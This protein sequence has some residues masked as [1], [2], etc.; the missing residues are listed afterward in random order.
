MA[1]WRQGPHHG[2]RDMLTITSGGVERHSERDEDEVASNSNVH[3]PILPS[4]PHLLVRRRGGLLA[5][6]SLLLLC[7]L[8]S[9][10]K[11]SGVRSCNLSCSSLLLFPFFI[12][13]LSLFFFLFLAL[14][15]VHFPHE[16]LLCV[17]SVPVCLQCLFSHGTQLSLP[18]HYS[19][20][21]LPFVHIFPLSLP[22]SFISTTFNLPPPR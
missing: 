4:S 7:G 15:L 10:G 1:G 2:P 3:A 13:P 11:G 17:H 18:V 22:H 8:W 6:Y 16:L 19:L 14:P 21:H 12:F 5:A 9:G 20:S